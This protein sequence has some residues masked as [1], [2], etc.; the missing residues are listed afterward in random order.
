M[1]NDKSYQ[2]KKLILALSLCWTSLQFLVCFVINIK[3]GPQCQ[4]SPKADLNSALRKKKK[5][6][7]H[8]KRQ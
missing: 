4:Q 7:Q 8:I 2:I 6:I 1:F 3:L 5:M